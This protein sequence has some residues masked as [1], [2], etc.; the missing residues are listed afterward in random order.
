MTARVLVVDDLL[1]T[2]QAARSAAKR[3]IF[4]GFDRDERRRCLEI[5][6]NGNCDIVLLDVMMSGMDG[7]E[8]CFK[9]CF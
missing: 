3:R 5:C 6:A 1:P 9:R 7:L 4:R 8:V 2:S